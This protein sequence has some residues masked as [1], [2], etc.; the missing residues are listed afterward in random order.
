MA[1]NTCRLLEVTLAASGLRL[2]FILLLL[3]LRNRSFFKWKWGVKWMKAE[4]LLRADSR[5][6]GEEISQLFM[7][8]SSSLPCVIK[9]TAVSY[10]VID[11][12]TVL[13]ISHFFKV[14]VEPAFAYWPMPR[15][16]LKLLNWGTEFH[17][18]WYEFCAIGT[19]PNTVLFNFVKSVITTWW[20]HVTSRALL[21]ALKCS[22]LIYIC[23]FW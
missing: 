13:V 12:P 23:N 6:A 8:A 3:M 16:P 7:T 15:N 18:T 11:E 10:P 20:M 2:D 22:V 21:K 4:L 1:M 14:C 19:H 5:W 17:E 9:R